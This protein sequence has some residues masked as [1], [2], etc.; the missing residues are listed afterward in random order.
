M[1]ATYSGGEVYAQNGVD[2][3]ILALALFKIAFGLMQVVPSVAAGYDI[4]EPRAVGDSDF[5][6][7]A[8]PLADEA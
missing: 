2:P 1:L 4:R 5:G 8:D 6:T 7:P 3:D